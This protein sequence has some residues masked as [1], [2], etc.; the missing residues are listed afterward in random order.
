M[1]PGIDLDQG[2]M[3]AE[4]LRML[5]EEYGFSIKEKVTCSFGVSFYRPSESSEDLVQRADAALQRAKKEG[6]NR[7]VAHE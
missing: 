1:A 3:F 2:R 6:R 7:C 4:K 5:V